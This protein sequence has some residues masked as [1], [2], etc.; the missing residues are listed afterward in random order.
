MYVA[1]KILL[2]LAFCNNSQE[3][4]MHASEIIDMFGRAPKGVRGVI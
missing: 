1:I 3:I 4:C 2:K